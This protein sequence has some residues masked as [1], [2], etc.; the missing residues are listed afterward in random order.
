MD[1]FKGTVYGHNTLKCNHVHFLASLH[2]KTCCESPWWMPT[3]TGRYLMFSFFWAENFFFFFHL[4][5]CELAGVKIGSWMSISTNF[6]TLK[7]QWIEKLRIFHTLTNKVIKNPWHF[8]L[9][10]EK[11]WCATCSPVLKVAVLCVCS[12]NFFFA[13][14]IRLSTPAY[15]LESL[16]E[17]LKFT[18]ITLPLGEWGMD[19]SITLSIIILLMSTRIAF[20]TSINWLIWF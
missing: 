15:T 9:S 5:S 16:G 18:D 11:K 20:F 8:V 14:D 2:I 1:F 6:L 17:I 12:W 4:P 3:E 19:L 10:R 7:P 13:N